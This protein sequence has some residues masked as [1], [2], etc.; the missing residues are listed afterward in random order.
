M[1]KKRITRS[2]R[3]FQS[4]LDPSVLEP[5]QTKAK[6]NRHIYPIAKD[7]SEMAFMD[8][9]HRSHRPARLGIGEAGIYKGARVLR[10]VTEI[11]QTTFNHIDGSHVHGDPSKVPYEPH[12]HISTSNSTRKK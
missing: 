3:A 10:P 6:R 4:F 2:V 1:K 5:R 12:G 7:T 8:G 11:Q 9:N